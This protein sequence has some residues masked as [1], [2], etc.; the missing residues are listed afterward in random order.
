MVLF[1]HQGQAITVPGWIAGPMGNQEPIPD[2]VALGALGWVPAS[3]RIKWK[4]SLVHGET[5]PTF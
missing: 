1:P 2:T 3:G 4:Q 5:K